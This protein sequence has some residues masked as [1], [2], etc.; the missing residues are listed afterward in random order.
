MD[1]D[2]GVYSSNV[3]S[4]T[5]IHSDPA[6]AGYGVDQAKQLAEKILTLDPPVDIVYSSPFY[7]CLQTLKPTTEQLFQERGGGKVRVENGVGEFYGRARFD[8]PSPAPLSVLHTHF[9]DLD[10]DYTP[11]IIPSTNG[12]TIEGLHNRIAYALHRIV[13]AVDA[14]PKSPRALLICTHAASM[15]AMGR[16]LTGRMP[17]DPSEDDFKCFTCSLSKFVRRRKENVAP[18]GEDTIGGKW[19]RA[20]PDD[21]PNVGWR[22][23]KGVKGGWNCELNG[24]CSFLRGGEERGWYF[25][26]D[27]AF[28]ADPNAYNDRLNTTAA[29]TVE[30]TGA[31]IDEHGKASRL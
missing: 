14:D 12:E 16:V 28:L 22:N 26:G 19:D 2:T 7:R 24:D 13:A 30:V 9:P 29:I 3:P 1:P 18:N 4:P 5:G 8:H 20:S 27:E 23:G 15:I 6:L 25:S 31:E 17:K 11:I 10:P 21:I